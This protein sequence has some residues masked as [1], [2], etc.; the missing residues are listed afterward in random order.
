VTPV[1]TYAGLFEALNW[2]S[3][4]DERIAAHWVPDGKGEPVRW[5]W[6]DRIPNG[7]L[8]AGVC[9]VRNSVHHQ[10][11]DAMLLDRGGEVYRQRMAGRPVGHTLECSA[12]SS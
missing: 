8:M 9:Y 6:R 12:A 11:S 3:A 4:L 7:W 1:E 5:A 10:W 2:A